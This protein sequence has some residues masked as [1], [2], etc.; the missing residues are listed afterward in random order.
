MAIAVRVNGE[1]HLAGS[2][3][4]LRL[5]K[6]TLHTEVANDRSRALAQRLGFVEEGVL[7]AAIAFPNE[8]RDDLAYA[9]LA[10]EWPRDARATAASATP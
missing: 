3:G 4:P 7:R 2:V 6:A 8:R 9:L 5:D 10:S 1:R